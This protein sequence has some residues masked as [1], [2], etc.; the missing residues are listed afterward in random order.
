MAI[1][2]V[3]PLPIKDAGNDPVGVM[4]GQPTNECDGVLVG[5]YRRWPRTWQRQFYFIECATLPSD[6][7]MRSGFITLDFDGNLFN[8]GSQ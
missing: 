4:M 6:C 2:R 7:K 8:D 3:S 5:P 1:S